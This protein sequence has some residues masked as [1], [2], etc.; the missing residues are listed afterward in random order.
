[1]V[2]RVVSNGT[3]SRIR[4]TR[5]RP[6]NGIDGSSLRASFTSRLRKVMLK[7]PW[8]EMHS[9]ISEWD[10]PPVER[11]HRLLNP[12]EDGIRQSTCS[13]HRAG[14]SL[15]LNC[16]GRGISQSINQSTRFRMAVIAFVDMQCTN[17]QHLQQMARAATSPA[18]RER[19]NSCTFPLV[20]CR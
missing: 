7:I 12:A 4:P 5:Q 19:W 15:T 9:M 1:V 3:G 8:A 18:S 16:P 17:G 14:V 20:L 6:G 11:M 2:A 13:K 10:A